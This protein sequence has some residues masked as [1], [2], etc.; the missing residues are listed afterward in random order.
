MAVTRRSWTA[1]DITI[2][3]G[4]AGKRTPQQIAQELGR[5]IGA[6]AVEASKLELSLNTGR[7]AGRPRK[8]TPAQAVT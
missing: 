2:L 6:V 8:R 7:R 4:L 1:D 3:K 5:T